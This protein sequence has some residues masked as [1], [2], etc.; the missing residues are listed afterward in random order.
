MRGEVAR[1]TR[2]DSAIRQ[3]AGHGEA[4]R[5]ELQEMYRHVKVVLASQEGGRVGG[6][7]SLQR[8]IAMV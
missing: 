8:G 4:R 3:L 7:A 2:V 6:T 1:Q 5:T